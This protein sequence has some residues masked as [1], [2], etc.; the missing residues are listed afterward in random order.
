MIEVLLAAYNG[1]RYVKEQIDSILNQTCQQFHLT[2]ADDGSQDG[3]ADILDDY[4]K[5]Y[6]GKVRAARFDSP[7]RSAQG[8]FFRLLGQTEEE[9]VMLS[10]QDDVWI[11]EK[12][13]L[14]LERMKEM[15]EHCGKD[16]PILVHGDLSVVD[17][18]L[19]VIHPSMR[20]YQKLSPGHTKLR[21]YLVE[22]NITGNT[23]MINRALLALLKTAPRDC[24]MH[25]WWMG[26]VAASFGKISYIEK[27]LTLYRQHGNNQLGAEDSGSL[28]QYK[29]RLTSGEAVRE[30]YRKMF[31]QAECFLENF[32]DMLSEGQIELLEAFLKIPEMGRFGI[33]FTVIRWGLYKSTLLRTLG[34]MWFIG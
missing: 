8:N 23:V 17:E 12:I 4:E 6:P 28:E 1:E 26:L 18:Q 7:S 34:Q 27:P 19:R 3:T 20:H 29:K 24:C 21:H 14:T 2:A 32:K 30:N 11:P 13:E 15:E 25:D 22:N 31:L 16:T 33:M 5:R 9:Y 10:D